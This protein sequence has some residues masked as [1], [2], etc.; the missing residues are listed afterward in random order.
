MNAAA[1]VRA[2]GRLVIGADASIPA[3]Q[4]LVRWDP[5]GAAARELAERAE[6]RFPPTARL[7]AVTGR[8]DAVHELLD[9]IQLPAGSELLGTIP[10]GR[11]GGEETERALLRVPRGAG[12][13]LATALKMAA[14]T[15]SA[16]TAPDP[17]R[18]VLDPR[19]LA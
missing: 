16:R 6:L 2:D 5:A 18:I 7:A 3:V 10:A 9:S 19:E 11:P 4:A 1:L 13:Q 14:A 12:A 15:R 17:V 8:P